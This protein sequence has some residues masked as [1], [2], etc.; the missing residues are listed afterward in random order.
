MIDDHFPHLSV[1]Q[2]QRDIFSKFREIPLTTFG[3]VMQFYPSVADCLSSR[4][5]LSF[6]YP[7]VYFVNI[8]SIYENLDFFDIK[9]LNGAI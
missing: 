6:A 4:S 1:L 3:L 7:K 2:S 9:L 8:T 5:L